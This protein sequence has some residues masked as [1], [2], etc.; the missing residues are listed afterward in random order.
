MEVIKDFHDLAF[1]VGLFAIA[2][3]PRAIDAYLAVRNGKNNHQADEQNQRYPL[4]AE[5]LFSMELN[6]KEKKIWKH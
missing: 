3:A 2:M 4:K 5:L 6:N 1:V